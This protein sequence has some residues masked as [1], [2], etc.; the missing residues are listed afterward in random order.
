MNG[1]S[2]VLVNEHVAC[3]I[4]DAD[5]H[6]ACMEI[7]VLQIQSGLRARGSTIRVVHPVELIDEAYGPEPPASPTGLL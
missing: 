4:E 7:G 3:A 1:N 6:G 5:V 2:H